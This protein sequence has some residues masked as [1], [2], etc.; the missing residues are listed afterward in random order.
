[1]KKTK[2]MLHFKLYFMNKNFKKLLGL[3]PKNKRRSRQLGLTDYDDNFNNNYSGSSG[4]D[5]LDKVYKYT[6]AVL[7][8]FTVFALSALFG[9]AGS[10]GDTLFSEATKLLGFYIFF[11]PVVSFL[12][13]LVFFFKKL[14]ILLHPTMLLTYLLSFLGFGMLG[15]ENLTGAYG[16]F[17]A[18]TLTNTIGEISGLFVLGV[19]SLATFN[20]LINN[21]LAGLVNIKLPNFSSSKNVPETTTQENLNIAESANNLRDVNINQKPPSRLKNFFAKIFSRSVQPD[22]EM[23]YEEDVEHDVR[24]EL[25]SGMNVRPDIEAEKKK[26]RVKYSEHIAD[27]A[28]ENFNTENL[29]TNIE[30]LEPENVQ[31]KVQRE[32]R[33]R[34]VVETEKK[35]KMVEEIEKVAYKKPPLSYYEADS[36]K[37]SAG[38]KENAAIIKRTF[39]HFGV[40]VEMAGSTV[41][42]TVTRY[43]LK[44]AQGVRLE[45]IMSYAKNIALEIGVESVNISTIP[46]KS[47]VGIE[48]PNS[49]KAKI[50]LRSLFSHPKF[51]DNAHSLSVALGKDLYGEPYV[52]DLAKMPH[53]LVA[54]TTGAGKSI[55][56]HT[57]IQS[58]IQ[59]KS[60]YDLKLI[61]IDPKKVELKLYN[62]LPHL[63]TPVIIE[64]KKAIKTL[65]W[66][67]HEM[68]RRYEIL[69]NNGKQKIDSYNEMVAKEYAKAEKTKDYSDLPEKLP[70]IVLFFDEIADFMMKYPKEIESGVVR[71]AQMSRAVGIHLILATQR[72][73]TNILT[74]VIKGNIPSRVALKVATRI[75]SSVIIDDIGAEKLLGNGDMLFKGADSSQVR[76]IQ[77]ALVTEDEI[78]KVTNFLRKEY[79]DC[80]AEDLKDVN[81]GDGTIFG[82]QNGTSSGMASVGDMAAMQEEDDKFDEAREAVIKFK[83]ASTSLLQRRLS[84]GYSRA[85]KLIDMLESAGIVGA[86]QGSKPRKVLVDESG[87]FITDDT[88]PATSGKTEYLDPKFEEEIKNMEEASK[89]AEQQNTN[90]SSSGFFKF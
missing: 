87:K 28:M 89:K 70:F 6:A 44:P 40:N 36:G 45:K 73:S 26:M 74:G 46:E 19:S 50:G 24:N 90:N 1:M 21:K 88:A 15:F 61:M 54:G 18:Q 3:E 23:E 55:F 78:E 47:L 39:Q 12:L 66:L 83:S 49:Q 84:V 41:G 53:L 60:P 5:N 76:R 72:P 37:A 48:V 38:N 71:L 62:K 34:K 11:I 56:I 51:T 25:F 30:N 58:L 64:A 81:A 4:A 35:R 8:F 20:A 75:D 22:T 85:A 63:M 33:K 7:L 2:N 14:H 42:P 77:G 69:G 43:D 52:Y 68:D 32:E 13:S 9:L 57:I 16:D 27:D 67:I 86:Q 59:K 80:I 82:A 31:E 17:I 65:N 10:F 29:D 79:D